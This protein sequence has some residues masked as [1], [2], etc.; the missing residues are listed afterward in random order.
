M[1]NEKIKNVNNEDKVNLYC[2]P[3]D[4][5]RP[6]NKP[7]GSVAMEGSH[8]AFREPKIENT[9]TDVYYNTECKLPDS[10]VAVPTYDAV[11]EAKEWVDDENKK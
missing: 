2:I 9:A 1:D 11:V 10:E 8:K 6:A 4:N 7:T 5:N 3:P